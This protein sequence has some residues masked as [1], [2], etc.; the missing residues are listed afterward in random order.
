M[1]A[2]SS[3]SSMISSSVLPLDRFRETIELFTT[4]VIFDVLMPLVA[5]VAAIKIFGFKL[6]T[7]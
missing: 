3:S 7:L 5:L 1:M 6:R 2:A 4:L